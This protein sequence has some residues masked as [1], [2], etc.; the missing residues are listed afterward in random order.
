MARTAPGALRRGLGRH[1]GA[2][3]GG[4]RVPLL[5]DARGGGR[6]DGEETETGR[7]TGDS[8]LGAG[9]RGLFDGA[10]RL[11]CFSIFAACLVCFFFIRD[12][13]RFGLT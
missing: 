13:G 9:P 2:A 4:G 7:K 1:H 5:R 6:W 12:V 11:W 10:K 8:M 3:R